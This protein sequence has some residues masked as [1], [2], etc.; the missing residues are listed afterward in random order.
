MILNTLPI[1]EPSLWNDVPKGIVVS[2]ISSETPIFFAA[3]PE[4]V[5]D[6]LEKLSLKTI[7]SYEEYY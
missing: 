1:I 4:L 5:E 6:K 7:I 3:F 2:A